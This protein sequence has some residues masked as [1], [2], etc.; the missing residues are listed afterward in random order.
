MG[1]KIKPET[2]EKTTSRKTTPAS[3]KNTKKEEEAFAA[4]ERAVLAQGASQKEV[5]KEVSDLKE[6]ITSLDGKV[7]SLDGK[8]TS[9]DEKVNNLDDRVT[10]LEKKVDEG[11][12]AVDEKFEA[13]D[14]RFDDID[15][16]FEA[17][18]RRFEAVDKRFDGIDATL[19]KMQETMDDI[20]HHV[21]RNGTR[22]GVI[23]EKSVLRDVPRLLKSH[24]YNFDSSQVTC[25]YVI[26]N[27]E[28]SSAVNEVDSLIN[29]HGNYW[30]IEV[31]VA[32]K[33]KDVAKH[34]KRVERLVEHLKKHDPNFKQVTG[35]IVAG[36]FFKSSLEKAAIAGFY[37]F[38]ISGVQLDLLSTPDFQPKK[39]GR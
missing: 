20:A 17:V 29:D 33:P 8:V 24:G 3:Q 7:T 30:A 9:L 10:S 25:N 16:R 37:A 15:K 11:F 27:A 23:V 6:K 19:K 22:L 36:E 2:K 26:P 4:L 13:V 35:I 28:G 32:A 1:T 34:L 14:R 38:E 5:K 18:D 12:K 39:F 31:K 21:N